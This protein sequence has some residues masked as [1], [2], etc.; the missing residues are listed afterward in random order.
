MSLHRTAIYIGGALLISLVL[1]RIAVPEWVVGTNLGFLLAFV[2]SAA[3]F[4]GL[5]EL[6]GLGSN[7]TSLGR[8]LSLLSSFIA[9]SALD[10][11]L[12]LDN[13]LP[14]S[15]PR[16]LVAF[17]PL[18]LLLGGAWWLAL[19]KTTQELVRLKPFIWLAFA[20]SAGC[21]V[22]LVAYWRGYVS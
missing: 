5:S 21:V 11:L 3:F 15:S 2:S 10:V 19:T 12:G 7:S 13:L 6:R 20:A 1:A 18:V 17:S 9:T 14:A 16:I 22:A 8:P 4:L